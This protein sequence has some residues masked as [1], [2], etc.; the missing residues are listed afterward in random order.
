MRQILQACLALAI[1]LVAAPAFADDTTSVDFT[2]HYGADKYDAGGLKS[3]LDTG[4]SLDGSTTHLGAT[5]IYRGGLLELGALGEWGRPGSDAKTTVLGLLGGVGF[6]VG[7]FRLEALGEAGGH[8]Y[9][10]QTVAGSSA[11]SWLVYV[12]LRPGLSLKF[13]PGDMLL[14]GVWGFARWDV[15]SRNVVVNAGRIDQATYE[16]GGTQYGASLRLGVRL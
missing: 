7:G 11:D 4:A 12:G 5:A 1:A 8:M 6:D 3:G 10:G 13:G 14:V 9:G 15:T 16:L 2:L